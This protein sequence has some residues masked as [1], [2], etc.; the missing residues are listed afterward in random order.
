MY[1]S[2]RPDFSRR[3]LTPAQE[4]SLVRFRLA[5]EYAKSILADPGAHRPYE[6]EAKARRRTAYNLIIS[7]Y[8]NQQIGSSCQDREERK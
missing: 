2:R 7:E 5:V 8:L 1:T 6:E 4:A 3:V